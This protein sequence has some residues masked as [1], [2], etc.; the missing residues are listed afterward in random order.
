MEIYVFG[1]RDFELKGIIES[2]KVLMFTENLKDA[3]EFELICPMDANTIRFM[4]T[5]F[6]VELDRNRQ[7]FGV[8]SNVEKVVDEGSAMLTFSGFAAD[9]YLKNRIIHGTYQSADNRRMSQIVYDVVNQN[10]ANPTDAKRKWPRFEVSANQPLVGPVVPS[11]QVT[12]KQ[13]DEF[14]L[15]FMETEDMIGYRV[16]TDINAGTHTFEVTYGVDRTIEQS[17]VIPVIFSE[18]FDNVISQRYFLN[19]D[20]LK[21]YALIAGEGEGPA[22]VHAK[23]GDQYSGYDRFELYVDARDEQSEID[24]NTTLTPGQYNAVLEA[25]G[26]EELAEWKRVEIFEGEAFTGGK[27]QYGRDYFVGD[28]VTF[29]DKPMGMTMGAVVTS[30]RTTYKADMKRVEITYGFGVPKFGVMLAR[31]LR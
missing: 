2:A 15:D 28:R 1:E 22:R 17:T 4:K 11:K 27:F 23:V 16:L 6:I 26:E 7:F 10:I 12:G 29:V 20:N 14:L 19:N 30:A 13:L 24:E 31:R 21:N 8:I 9:G 25:R 3:G 18:D 5:G